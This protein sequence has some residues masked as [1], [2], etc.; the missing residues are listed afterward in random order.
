MSGFM[1]FRRLPNREKNLFFAILPFWHLFVGYY[2]RTLNFFDYFQNSVTVKIR[3]VYFRY[4]S[5]LPLKG[6]FHLFLEQ[7]SLKKSATNS[8]RMKTIYEFLK[9]VADFSH[10]RWLPIEGIFYRRTNLAISIRYIS[11][12]NLQ[13]SKN[14]T[15]CQDGTKR[16]REWYGSN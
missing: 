6:T 10:S 13:E 15:S 1:C 5:W 9:K 16:N 7:N 2:L 12:K 4:F 14:I 8:G 3:G 11:E